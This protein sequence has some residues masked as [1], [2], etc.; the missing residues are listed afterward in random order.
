M[1][2]KDFGLYF[3]YIFLIVLALFLRLHDLGI[4]VFHHDEAAVGYFTYKLF[5]DGIYSYDPSFHGPF[6]YYVTAEMFRHFGDNIYAA[7]LLPA[8][9]GATMLLFLIPLRKYI[10][11]TGMVIAAFFYAISPSFLYY[12]RF[13]REDIFI[14][15]F[16]L[17][18]LVCAVKYAENYNVD[19]YSLFRPFY[20]FTGGV[21]LASLAALKENAYITAAL[22]LFF[23]LLVIIREKLFS[24]LFEKIK[25]LDKNLIIIATESLLLCLVVILCFS[26]FYTGK[27]LDIAG[28]KEAFLKAILHWYE[29]HKTER[30]GGPY[31]FYLP[32]LALYELP[33]FVFSIL[34]IAYYGCCE[35]KK[36]KILVFLLA[37]WITA[38]IMYY[39]SDIYPA[40]NKFFPTAYLPG[41]IIVFFPLVVYG[42]ATV[43]KSRNLFFSFLIYW[44]LANLA[45][46]SYLQEKVP[47]LILNPLL[48]LVL[49]AAS[50]I[51]GV[52][53]TIKANLRT[54]AVIFLVVSSSY[55]VYSS[56]FL[57]Y[58]DYTNPAEPLIQAA[59]PPQKYSIFIDKIFE[60]SA[61]YQNQ[62]TP[63]QITDTEMETQFLWYLRHYATLKWKVNVDSEL[64][65]PLIVVHDSDDKHEPDLVQERLGYEYQR[66]NSS[67]MSW[68]WFKPSDITLDY[69]LSRKMDRAPGE[70]RI[71]LFYRPRNK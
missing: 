15:F 23:L 46:Y 38:D 41:S 61:Q 6:M 27:F 40:S 19:G 29:M 59:Q 16:S 22:I 36:E 67:K 44:A 37:Y 28:M 4:R 24:N 49:I 10:G 5:N 43:L 21:A 34:G 66:L 17:L 20:L 2:K 65:A 7:R 3:V 8:I 32:I 57:N 31:F 9:L 18:I 63:L 39:I 30:I 45:I 62:S 26:L 1:S 68:Y 42:I 14:S 50:Y 35:G 11:K 71:V 60:I 58:Y 51:G 54:A 52:L 64:D 47:W 12:S 69:L 56:V 13:Y 53:P 33:V 48:P 55:L 25:R 70:Y